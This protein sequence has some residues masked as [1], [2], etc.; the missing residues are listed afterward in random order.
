MDC[1]VNVQVTFMV[2]IFMYLY[3]YLFKGPDTARYPITDPEAEQVDQIKDLMN[4]RY[5][6]ACEAMRRIFGFEIM[7]KT[8]CGI[9]LLVYLP[10]DN[11]HQMPRHDS[12]TST[13][14][15]LLRYFVRPHIDVFLDLKYTEFY[16]GLIHKPFACDSI[17]SA[18]QWL[19][20]E[21]PEINIPQIISA[22]AATA[23]VQIHY[24]LREAF[25]R[26]RA[27]QNKLPVVHCATRSF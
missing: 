12:N 25:T 1:H 10:G 20:L 17:L 9:C 18:N 3:K 26:I 22:C 7:R 16:T 5:V 19:E 14:T 4:A 24:R 27:A 11:F 2:N 21:S 6:S 15:K 8:P 23:K 13:A